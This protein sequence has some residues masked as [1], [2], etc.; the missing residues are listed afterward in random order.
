MNQQ[1]KQ[2]ARVWDPIQKKAVQKRD[3][4]GNL[5][6]YDQ[7][8]KAID[9]TWLDIPL[10]NPMAQ[11][12]ANIDYSTQK[13]EALLERI[14]KTSSDENMLVAD[15][16][17]GSGVTAAVA[18]KLNRRFIHCDIGVNSIQTTRD[19]LVANKA[20]FSI[21]EIKD[22]VSLYRNPV[23]TMD[24]M[25][26]I[27]Q[28][29]RNEDSLDEYWGGA[30]Q[31]S[32]KGMIPVYIPNLMDSTTKLLDIPIINEIIHKAIPNLPDGVKKIIVYY[33]DITDIDDIKKFIEKDDSTNIEIELRDLKEL[34]DDVVIEDSIDYKLEEIQEK[35]FKEY[36][37]TINKFV[38][39][40]VVQ[41]IHEYNEK[42]FAQTLKGS[43]KKYT[44]I[45]ISENGLETIEFISLDC[46]NVDG[47]WH[48][49]SEIKIDGKTSYVSINGN[50]KKEFWNGKIKSDKKPLRMKVRNICGD[51]TIIQII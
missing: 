17:G 30:I 50:K 44:P 25:K 20:E 38:S 6:Y 49:D 28:G 34:L 10:V 40:R 18:N 29:L 51:E 31:D 42:K 27:I 41:R 22:G 14:L 32:Q 8:D 7:S 15:F 46:T 2:T 16:F 47:L 43:D 37:V 23:Q 9:D 5:I 1:R 36:Q 19:R 26:S 13:P 39:D 11:E 48:S 45:T 24:K 12:R 35:L 4:N 21:K 3:E 33:V